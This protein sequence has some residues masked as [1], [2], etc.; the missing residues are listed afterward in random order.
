MLVY[1]GRHLHRYVNKKSRGP[2]AAVVKLICMVIKEGHTGASCAIPT[3]AKGG[4]IA[5]R[6]LVAEMCKFLNSCVHAVVIVPLK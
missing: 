1:R 4:S 6:I 3:P 5:F 2:L